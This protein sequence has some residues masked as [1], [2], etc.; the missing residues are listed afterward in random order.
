MRLPAEIDDGV[1]R[2]EVLNLC[3]LSVD[4]LVAVGFQEFISQR[5]S[6]Q[7]NGLLYCVVALNIFSVSLR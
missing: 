3:R 7:R 5:V 1:A 6:I 2:H 4:R